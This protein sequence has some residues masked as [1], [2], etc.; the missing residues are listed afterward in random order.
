GIRP[1]YVKLGALGMPLQVRKVEDVGRHKVVRGSIEGKEIA[2]IL[3]EDEA[4]P[5]SPRV[6][7]DPAG[8]NIYQ[9]SWRVDLGKTGLA[10]AGRV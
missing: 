1:E 7:F 2:A 3:G 6:R 10:G 8:I 4:L 5:A 9:D